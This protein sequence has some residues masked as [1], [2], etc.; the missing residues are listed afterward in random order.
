MQCEILTCDTAKECHLVD[1]GGA[2]KS[3]IDDMEENCDSMPS[4]TR[5]LD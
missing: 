3:S 5:T 4:Y 2:S 1:F